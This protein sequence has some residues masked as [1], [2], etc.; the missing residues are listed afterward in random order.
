M[1]HL[2]SCQSISHFQKCCKSFAYVI[3]TSTDKLNSAHTHPYYWQWQ[4]RCVRWPHCCLC[5]S[6]V[7]QLH[8]TSRSRSTT[9]IHIQMH[10]LRH[11]KRLKC[12]RTFSLGVFFLHRHTQTHTIFQEGH[13]SLP[14]S[15]VLWYHTYSKSILLQGCVSMPQQT[16]PHPSLIKTWVDCSSFLSIVL[17]HE[18]TVR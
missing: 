6:T 3:F 17:H 16:Q 14:P 11:A 4:P 1:S 8:M 7:L 18:P 15:P 5:S 9:H 13:S 12:K 2:L 10:A